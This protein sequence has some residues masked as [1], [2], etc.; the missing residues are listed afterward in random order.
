MRTIFGIGA[1]AALALG[2]TIAA[3]TPAYADDRI[4]RGTI[5]AVS[6][7][8]NVKVPAGATCV[9]NGTRIDGNVIV[10]RNATLRATAARVDGNIQSEGHRVVAVQRSSVDGSIQLKQGGGMTLVGNRVGGDI[11]VFSNTKGTK[12]IRGNVIDGNLQCKA[13]R[14]APVGGGNRVEGNKE[15]QCRRL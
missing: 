2:A 11:Q 5:G 10:N 1:T 15:D 13:N 8:D 3:A 9:L 12:T 4:C 14:P 6:I 7:G